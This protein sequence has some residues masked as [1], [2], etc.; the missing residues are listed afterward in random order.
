MKN[1]RTDL[2]QRV[3]YAIIAGMAGVFLIPQVGFAAPTG[4][5]AV[6]GG[7]T[8]PPKSSDMN[9]TSSSANNVITW[10]DYSIAQ[11]ERVQYD[12]GA[13]TNN[14]LNIVTGANTSNINGTIEGGKD[15]YIVNPNGVIFG[16]SAQVNVGNLYVSTQ[17]TGTLNQTNFTGTGASPLS[18]TD[19]GLSDVVNMGNIT[20][21]KV[22]VYGKNIRFLNAADVTTTDPV[23]LHTDTANG[24]YA[25]IGYEKAAGAPAAAKYQIN[26]ANAAAVDNYYQLVS[27]K[28]ELAAINTTNL[29]GNYML[30]DDIDLANAAHTPIGGNS[31]GAFT[32]KFD[33]NFFQI[34]NIE[35]SGVDNAGLFGVLNGASIYNVGVVG[36]TIASSTTSGIYAGGIAGDARN[37]HL[38]NVYVKGTKVNGEPSAHGGLVGHTTNTTIDGAY[39]KAQVG[40]DGVGIVGYAEPGTK[41]TNT[42]NDSVYIAHPNTAALFL[43]VAATNTAVTIGNSYTMSRAISIADNLIEDKFNNVFGVSASAGKMENLKTHASEDA[44]ASSTY[45][46]FSIN[47]DGTPGAKWRIYEGQTLPLLTA[48]MN[49]RVDSVGSVGANYSYRKFNQ[50]NASAVDSAAN[51][52]KS[53]NHADIT[54]LTYDSKIVKIVDGDGKI[55]DMSNVTYDKT[56]TDDQTNTVKMYTD[57]GTV[58]DTTKNVRNAGTKAILWS[59]Q[60][61]PNLRNVNVT[62]NKRSVTVEN[63]NIVATRRYDGTRNVTAAYNDAISN[64]GITAGGI[65]PEDIADGSVTITTSTDFKA[66]MDDKN[67]GEKKPVTL[68][69]SLTFGGSNQGNYAITAGDFIFG[70]AGKRVDGAATIT[71]APLILKVTKDASSKI[72]DGTDTVTDNAMRATTNVKLDESLIRTGETDAANIKTDADT[73]RKDDVGLA[74]IADPSYVDSTTG[75]PAIHAGKHTIR[76][77]NVKLKGDDA[78]NYQLYYQLTDASQAVVESDRIDLKGT[79]DRRQIKVDN[80]KV[81]DKDTH[82]GADATKVYDGKTTYSPDTSKVYLSSNQAG[83]TDTTGVVARDQGYI[84]FALTP[85]TA[86]FK[87]SDGTTD[88][89]NVTTADKIA[90][91]VRA[92]ADATHTDATY[93]EHHLLSDYWVSGNKDTPLTSATP[94]DATGAGKITPRVLTPEVVSKEIKKTYDGTNAYGETGGQILTLK[95]FADTDTRTNTSTLTYA[96]KNVVSDTVGSTE[97][98]QDITYH[99]SFADG[100][101]AEES[102]NYTLDPTGATITKTLDLTQNSSGDHY[103]GTILRRPLTLTMGTVSKIYDGTAENKVSGITGITNVAAPDTGVTAETLKTKH[104]EMLTA[105]TAESSYGRGTGTGFE[106]NV[107]A[108]NKSVRYTNMDTVFRSA[109]DAVKNNYTVDATIYGTGTITRRRID[110]ASFNVYKTSDNTPAAAK[111]VYDGTSKY[112]PDSG[113]Y[114]SA[115]A[116]AVGD[117]GIVSR[118]YNKVKFA[119]VDDKSANFTMADGTTETSH[120]SEASRIA[121]KIVATTTDEANNPL[122][123]YEFGT[124]AAKRNL[125]TV[126][127]NNPGRVSTAGSITAASIQATT[128][129]IW[130]VYDAKSEHRDVNRE[131]VKGDSLVTFTGWV[132]GQIR[133]NT[134]T[135]LYATKD[136]ARDS[137]GNVIKKSVTY[138]AQLTGQ[139]ADDYQIVNGS[140]AVI[141]T[142][143]S[144]SGA[145]KTVTANLGTVA[146]AG[147]IRPRALNITMAS[148]SKVYDTDSTNTAAN[149]TATNQSGTVASITA[150]P[151]SSKIADILSDDHISK[152]SI[153]AAWRALRDH[154][155]A[156]SDYGHRGNRQFYDANASAAA[157]GHDVKYTDMDTAFKNQFGATAAGNY[158]V[159]A[160]VYG[161]GTI[162]PKAIDPNNFNVEDRPGHAADASKVYDGTS[163][164]TV[165]KDWKIRPSTGART[166]LF[167]QDA[168]RVRFTL[169]GDGAYFIDKNGNKT[170]HA[171]NTGA[172][173]TDAD[174]AKV[175]YHV[176]AKAEDGFDYL[177]KNY[178]LNGKTLDSGEAS[179]TGAGKIER[180]TINVGL[181]EKT[182]IDKVYD[183]SDAL[184]NGTVNGK[185]LHHNVFVESDSKANVGYA[186]G[187][188]NANKL[189]RKADG[190]PDATVQVTAKYEDKDV[191]RSGGA[192][193]AKNITYKVSIAD[194]AGKNYKLSDGTNPAVNA[195]TGLTLSATGKITPKD[196]SYAL[197][198]V[199]KEY[200]G[201]TNVPSAQVGFKP[202]AVISGDV[203]SLA[204][205]NESF[206]S[207]NVN[208]DGTTETIDGTAQKNWVNYANLSLTGADA[209]NYKISSTAKGLG[210]ITKA[211]LNLGD[212][213]FGTPA[214]A[215]KVYDGTPDVKY[216]GSKPNGMP[217]DYLT[218]AMWNGHNILSAFDAKAQ[219]DGS[220][221]RG[222]SFANRVTYTL[223]LSNPANSNFELGTLDRTVSGDGEI[224]PKPVTATVKGALSKVYD[225]SQMVMGVAENAAG[226]VVTNADDLIKLD[227][228]VSG[229][230]AT[231]ISTALYDHADIDVGEQNRRVAY[232]V[233]ID[234]AHAGNYRLVDAG[235]AAITNPITT[236]NN[237][238]TKRS[239]EV[240]FRDLST[241]KTYNGLADNSEINPF[242]SSADAAV[243]HKDKATLISGTD[244]QNLTGI[245]SKYVQN[246]R[247]TPDPNAG[248]NKLVRFDHIQTAMNNVLGAKASNYEF[249][250]SGFARGTINKA[251]VNA[252]DIRLD[253]A[254]AHKVYDGTSDILWKDSA[255]GVFYGDADHVKNYINASVTLPGNANP[256]DLSNAVVMDMNATK[257]DNGQKNAT[258]PGQE[259]DVTYAFTIQSSNIDI[260]GSLA[261]LHRKGTID[262]RTLKLGLN[263]KVIE[264]KVYDASPNLIDTEQLHHNAFAQ[265]DAAANV[266]Y[267]AGTANENK[268]VRRVNGYSVDDGAVLSVTGQYDSKNVARD[269]DGKVTEQGITYT[270]QIKGKAGENYILSYKDGVTTYMRNAE[271]GLNTEINAKGVINPKDLSTVFQT[272]TKEYDGTKAVPASQVHITLQGGI[273]EDKV[274]LGGYTAKFQS[275]NVN[276][277]GSTWTPAGGTAQ[278]NWVHYTGLTLTGADARNYALASEAQG[279]GVIT[280]YRIKPDKDFTVRFDARPIEKVYDGTDA[281]DRSHVA[282]FN[283]T[284]VSG[285]AFTHEV[286]DARYKDGEHRGGRDQ[287]RVTYTMSIKP[288]P[289]GNLDNYDLTDLGTMGADRTFTRDTD[290]IIKARPVYVTV[291]GTPTKLYDAEDVLME[292]AVDGNGNV[293]RSSDQLVTFSTGTRESGTG[294]LGTD[295]T[296]NAATAVYTDTNVYRVGDQVQNRERGVRY[297]LAL[298]G[299]DVTDYVFENAPGYAS[300]EGGSQVYGDGRI[301]PR[302]LTLGFADA[303]PREYNGKTAYTGTKIVK[304][305]T[306]WNEDGR[307]RDTLKADGILAAD[308]SLA[309][310][311]FDTTAAGAH[312]GIGSTGENFQ[313]NA[314]AGDKV[315]QYTKLGDSLTNT[316]AKPNRKQNYEVDEKGYGKG[317]IDPREITSDQLKEGIRF[318]EVK[319]TYDGNRNVISE[320]GSLRDKMHAHAVDEHGNAMTDDDGR[321][322]DISK[323]I[324]I[325]EQASQYNTKNVRDNGTR[326]RVTYHLTYQG[327]NYKLTDTPIFE[328]KGNGKIIPRDIAAFFKTSPFSKVYDG[329]AELNAKNKQ[330]IKESGA[331]GVLTDDNVQVTATGGIYM[332]ISEDRAEKNATVDTQEIAESD[333]NEKKLCV[334]YD[335]A[336]AGSDADNY[337]IG[338]SETE[339]WHQTGS[340]NGKGDIYR[341]T[342]TV[343]VGEK[344]KPYDGTS[345]VKDLA[346]EDFT[347]GNLVGG[348]TLDLNPESLGKI[349]GQYLDDAGRPDPNVS[350]GSSEDKGAHK[351]IRYTGIDSA[352]R[353]M[354]GNYR[355]DTQ[356]SAA[357]YDLAA[358]TL[359]YGKGDEKSRIDPLKITHDRLQKGLSFARAE[360]TYDGTKALVHRSGDLKNYMAYAYVLDAVGNVLRDDAGKEIDIRENLT[361]DPTRSHYNVTAN[362]GDTPQGVTYGL[363]YD[364]VKNPNLNVTDGT[365]FD[366]SAV[367]YGGS[368]IDGTISRRKLRAALPDLSPTKTYDG[369]SEIVGR[370]LTKDGGALITSSGL[371]GYGKLS[372]YDPQDGTETIVTKDKDTVKLH[373]EA[374]YRD[375][376]VNWKGV[377]Q[378]G[379][380]VNAVADKEVDYTYILSGAGAENYDLVNERGES[381][382]RVGTNGAGVTELRSNDRAVVGTGRIAPYEIVLKSAP[383]HVRNNELLPARAQYEG[384]EGAPI[385]PNWK[386]GVA[387]DENGERKEDVLPGTIYYDVPYEVNVR[388]QRGYHPI[389]GYYRASEDAQYQPSGGARYRLPDGTIT[390]SVARNYRF[391]QDP[392][393]DTALFVDFYLPDNDY[394]QAL[395]QASKM[396]PNEYAYEHATLDYRSHFGRSAEAEIS[397]APPSINMVKDGVDISRNGIE[398]MDETVFRL[399]NEV[400]G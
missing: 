261:P 247:V 16:K 311:T 83:P 271:D 379:K 61:G 53:N 122:T 64:G 37:S 259:H 175:S 108:G 363:T 383:M 376:N 392:A 113:V 49:G 251:Q 365:K 329:N 254:H 84:T 231:N 296:R 22:E 336:L 20:A 239:V 67:V 362:A 339:G 135:A 225:A 353:A 116:A 120:V 93:N 146:N 198:N 1:Y 248:Q 241:P 348:E 288:A 346:K 125:E 117:T 74:D 287:H 128:H 55:G 54:G 126:N 253:A 43:G 330:E 257:Y 312:F 95:N 24:G 318:D 106:E 174:A 31:Y 41:I 110:P 381:I 82:V 207:E 159:D 244:V 182:D 397:Y 130:K 279:R 342:L 193:I 96:S 158:D 345:A 45:S 209:G 107:N 118:D 282:S 310:G 140:N 203:V 283:F 99:V 208:G 375:K 358:D 77:T 395:T 38:Y 160:T 361:V 359:T 44:H 297:D 306:P 156:T 8:I 399:V 13:K 292:R 350:P 14:Y 214:R 298:T 223:S 129:E 260:T 36:G 184:V 195:E 262:R 220:D 15:V 86:T 147:T 394:Y 372:L 201:T 42:Y 199:T 109:F 89:K 367:G 398:V 136:V 151:A 68:Y 324:A 334:K 309:A 211:T 269:A 23:V 40:V 227:G 343:A 134:S 119:L 148:V 273:A 226:N 237:T 112:T 26:G 30:A 137:N 233:G 32:G 355:L 79:I 179:V 256:I 316:V 48:F 238:I 281:A 213:V 219:Y 314:D 52:A 284:G 278:K 331:R 85:N 232:T 124:A 378:D 389:N 224:T 59:D 149:N 150:T 390:D 340:I 236:N 185:E 229:D 166:G 123:N 263:S 92:Q 242:V 313:S 252:N 35:V 5:T 6:S 183:R 377:E 57:T 155:E 276:G 341:R 303:E 270:A 104:T 4:G 172:A 212:V 115:N 127:A 354:T 81:Y 351:A 197:K 105:G 277:D 73:N 76:Y 18:T 62:I 291:N 87:K 28:E 70:A 170:A 181:A 46:G 264:P 101:N 11:G 349:R 58:L 169:S 145:T 328:Q 230:G 202:E 21:T 299:G 391:I 102:D 2:S 373:L 333:A 63:S 154:G 360:K 371:D 142:P 65:T 258:A 153:G 210:E 168:N 294:L 200:D 204:T 25:H 91:N 307:G 250:D 132:S 188:A 47:N 143:P 275:A 344:N 243:L 335:I 217:K 323:D 300:V 80:F 60:D 131:I 370:A 364:S 301:T 100:V 215:T 337:T 319:K 138:T 356:T 177:L 382:A 387:Y 139:Y 228:L 111:K 152:E 50:G 380:T 272:V 305:V 352:V 12:G 7:A 369:T 295:G 327:K 133:D 280:P 221:V 325:D 196:L 141:S 266:G 322:I 240:H 388:T 121:Y 33:G 385:G 19:A 384:A 98:A 205:H 366:V 78:T 317:R 56:L 10:Q 192:V 69:G 173:A 293:I 267:A 206:Q 274:A 27:T 308:G 191:A 9:I 176:T 157:E 144:G 234:A 167:S 164:F 187:T 338:G 3:R 39:S 265:E 326:S 290:G 178:T 75:N 88:T 66:E 29:A 17:D 304:E 103:T 235:G 249:N 186:A 163:D 189:A 368:A 320:T 255:T 289:G 97:K 194:D 245:S 161:K 315:V 246:D 165:D 90:Y 190:T 347:F 400:F 72:Y 114:L 71:K 162:T 396:L 180:R 94:F 332:H 374:Q 386:T 51:A 302:R 393:N 216:N 286:K 218:S 171:T 222:G 285:E 34:K 268:L 321:T 357:G